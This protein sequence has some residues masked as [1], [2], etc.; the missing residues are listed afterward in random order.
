MVRLLPKIYQI[1]V[2]LQGI[3][4]PIWRRLLI[5][6]DLFLHDFHKVLQTTMG[7]DNQHIHLF[8][9]G[10]KMFGSEETGWG[11]G[12]HFQDYT[13]I[14]VNDLLRQPGDKMIYQYDMGDDWRH[15]VEL[16]KEVNPDPD[17]YYPVCID[18]ARECPPEDC[19]GVEGYKEMIEAVKN[20]AS[21]HHRFFKAL[22]PEG[23]DPEYF[24]KEVINDFLMEEEY[25]CLYPYD[26]EED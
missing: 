3:R 8:L 5:P 14:R 1:T 2:T 19:G 26:E 21:P 12:P 7:W 6:A 9:K 4:P 17:A 25:G 24:D 18:G 11:S 13:A 16:E 20:P 15:A 10:N 22:F 23:M